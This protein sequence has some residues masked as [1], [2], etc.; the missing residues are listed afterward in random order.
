MLLERYY[1]ESLA[2]A[3]YL[4]GCEQTG[5]AIVIDP[6]RHVDTYVRAAAAHRLRIRYVTET[7]IHADY[8]SGARE[9]ARTRHAALVLSA[10]GGDA[11]S[12]RYASDD[13]ATLVRDGM[14]LNVG[15]VRLRVLHTPGHTP[16]H[17]SF[18]VT[19]KSTGDKPIG[20]VSGDF[21]FV[22]DVGRPDLREK[23]ANVQGSMDVAA[24]QLFGSLRRLANLPDFVQV[25]PG[26]GAGS[27]C[28]KSLS[29]VPQSTL[30]Y[31]RLYNPGLQFTS[32]DPF[33][34]WVLADQPEPPPYF[35]EMKRLNRDGPPDPP[36]LRGVRELSASDVDAAIAGGHWVVDAR[37]SAD[38]ARAHRAGSINIPAS[39]SFATYA[40]TVLTYDRP[41]VIIART[42][43]QALA[44]ARQLSLIGM[45]RVAG[46]AA[47]DVLQQKGGGRGMASSMK[48]LT[49][50]EL[51]ERMHNGTRVLDVR[52]RSEWNT[53]HLRDATHV[54]LGDLS[55]WLAG[56]R[57]DDSFVV[58]CQSGTR[59]SIAAS[60][61]MA[62]GFR[63]VANLTGGLDAWRD[64]GL[65]VE[66][67]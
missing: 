16:E 18:I 19:D 50:R 53:G 25:W 62:R 9:L 17:V 59:S 44:L 34:E 56:A 10:H 26:H 28:G 1:D 43:D 37:G 40:G 46:I 36:D 12:Y 42:R 5:D 23:A 15:R 7:H 3:S 60:I 29:A 20:I 24:R 39:R 58:H 2:Q 11:W 57:K 66:Q 33:V 38:F 54:Y 41:I 13:G 8:L 32:E 27:A 63:N 64:A 48:A 14:T 52:G 51:A 49:P 30:G 45:D 31:E 21:L 4:V 35:A 65:P 55:H 61:M 6:N 47:A 22:G 67:P